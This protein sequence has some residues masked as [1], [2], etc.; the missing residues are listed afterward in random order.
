LSIV[1]SNA[2]DFYSFDVCLK[3]VV[4]LTGYG[5]ENTIKARLASIGVSVD[6]FAI[7][8]GSNQARFSRALRGVTPFNNVE[9]ERYLKLSQELQELA[10]LL[11]PF[12][13]GTDARIIEIALDDFRSKRNE[14]WTQLNAAMSEIRGN[15][16]ETLKSRTQ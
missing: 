2:L 4:M 13:L 7:I 5:T 11:E 9:A 1:S 6:T 10:S 15:I 12:R 14:R 3:E 16:E 8:A